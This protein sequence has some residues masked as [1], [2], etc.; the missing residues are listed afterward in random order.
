VPQVEL[1]G[2][3]RRVRIGVP[4]EYFIEGMQ[5]EV[6]RAVRQA[7]EVFRSLGAQVTEISLPHTD[8]ALPVYYII[9]P[10]EAS[11]NLARYDGI[12]FGPRIPSVGAR[13]MAR[14]QGQVCRA[15]T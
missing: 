14:P 7:V 4:A 6:E 13:H 10:A 1:N 2:E 3:V 5:A 11:A 15:P 9:A 8:L 12:R